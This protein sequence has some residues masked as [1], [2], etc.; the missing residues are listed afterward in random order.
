VLAQ[1][2]GNSVR[3]DEETGWWN[4]RV[5]SI[6][7]V[8]FLCG[9]AFGAA[10]MRIYLHNVM[11]PAGPTMVINGHRMGLTQL[12]HELSL[13]AEQRLQVELILDDYAK[14]YQNLED[15]RQEVAEH[16]K[17]KIMELLDDQQ[18]AKFD[19]VLHAPPRR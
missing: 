3:S 7:A 16:G 9:S 8:V 15:Q 6:L 11:T 10:A 12:D 2:R 4:P 19:Q 1:G 17:Q 14:F 13:R 5:L 18:R